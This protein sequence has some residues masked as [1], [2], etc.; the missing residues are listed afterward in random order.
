MARSAVTA[1][2]GSSQSQMELQLQK[3]RRSVDFDTFDIVVQQIL[4]MVAADDIDIA[5]VYQRKFRWDDIRCAQLIESF[6]LGI[7]VPSLFMATNKD[8]TWELVDGVQRI[9]TLI[10]FA[11]GD[12]L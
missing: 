6:L 7:P 12:K 5:P 3:Q 1:D 11:G 2:N 9:S 8:S 10:K 4:T